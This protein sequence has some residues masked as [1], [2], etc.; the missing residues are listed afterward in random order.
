MKFCV[1]ERSATAKPGKY[2]FTLVELLVVIAIIGILVALLLPAVQAA[3]EAARRNQCKNNVKN[4]ALGCLL[5][6]DT[7]KYFPSGGWALNWVGDPNRGYG[8][9]Q[10]GSWQYSILPYIEESAIHDLGKGLATTDPVYR[11]AMEKMHSTPVPVFSCPSRRAMIP[12]PSPWGAGGGIVNASTVAAM[13]Q[14][15]GSIKSEYAANSGDA[16]FYAAEMLAGLR[17]KYPTGPNTDGFVWSVTSEC[18]NTTSPNFQYCQSGIMFYHS[19]LKPSQ[20]I[21]GTAS[22]YLLGE[23]LL[24]PLNYE[25]TITGNNFG[26]NQDIYAGYEMDNQRV[27]WS[28]YGEFPTVDRQEFYQPQQD[29]PGSDNRL[30]FGSAHSGGLNMAMCDGSVQTLSYDVDPLTHRYLA[31][32]FDGEVTNKNG[33]L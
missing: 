18:T 4:I 3:R 27:A 29:T 33:A 5:H 31:N 23:K 2:G 10:P 14:R 15:T 8:K 9:E 20:I 25:G 21:D 24:D 1:L 17:L 22:T 12:Y 7:H 19:E 13:A 28:P 30:A 26:D 32:R 16:K 6:V 11:T